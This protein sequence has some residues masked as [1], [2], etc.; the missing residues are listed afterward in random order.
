MPDPKDLA[1][2]ALADS[3]RR[4]ILGLLAERGECTA[5]EISDAITHVGRTTV[6]SHLRVLRMANLVAERRDGR[7]R[8]YSLARRPAQ[9]MVDFLQRLYQGSLADLRDSAE[10]QASA[11]HSEATDWAQSS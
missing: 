11:D 6:S 3:T 8:Y 9:D 5:S 2:E 10:H 7:F 4:Q 1:F